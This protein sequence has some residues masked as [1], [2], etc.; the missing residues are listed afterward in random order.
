MSLYRLFSYLLKKEVINKLLQIPYSNNAVG[1]FKK[2][3]KDVS[4]AKTFQSP[5]AIMQSG[6][7]TIGFAAGAIYV[8][9]PYSNNAVGSLVSILAESALAERAFQSPIAI[10]QSSHEYTLKLTPAKVIACFNPL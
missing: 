6:H 10:M 5:I 7:A 8:S 1:S 3:F 9:I 2:H 4:I